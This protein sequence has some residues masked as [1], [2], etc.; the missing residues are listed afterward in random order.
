VSRSSYYAWDKRPESKRTKENRTLLEKI[1][2]IH[3]KSKKVYGSVKITKIINTK[4]ESPV[5][6]KRIERIM[7]ENGIKSRVS[8]KFKATTNSNHR[9]P[10]AENIL[11]RDFSVDKPNQKMV[12]DITYLWTDEGWLYIAGVMDL[13][14]QK[15]VGLSMSERMT[16][17]IVI[18]ALNDAY[19]RVGRPTGVILHS[20]RGTQ[21]CSHEY[22]NLL[23]KYGFICSMSRKGNC[24]D[25]APMES[26][27][28]KLKCEC[29]YGQCFRT[30]EEARAA[31]FEYIEI[32]Y[33]RQRIH[34]SNDYITPE[35]YYN[36]L[37]TKYNAA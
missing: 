37:N 27:W 15:I 23:K 35:E 30:R 25:N 24:W 12:S 11:N 33:N 31:V 21:Y 7:S 6:H 26:F 19:Q 1:K 29:L 14:G 9:L 36:K 22:Q 3:N 13:C 2:L 10:V 17:D 28:G 34:A 32:F 4:S 20:D 5:N 8:K 16:K 18:N